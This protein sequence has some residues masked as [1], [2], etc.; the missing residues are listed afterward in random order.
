MSNQISAGG[1]R[2]GFLNMPKLPVSGFFARLGALAVDIILIVAGIHLVASTF[3]DFFFSI[4]LWAPYLTSG[5]MFFYFVALNGPYGRGQT[6]GKMILRIR[7]RDYAG[8]NITWRQAAL[9]TVVLFPTFVT[10]PI[11]YVLLP[12][13]QGVWTDFWSAVLTHHLF[14]GVA[15]A[16]LLV[17]PFNP[18]KQG[19]HDFVAE[20]LV[21]G[22]APDNAVSFS[23]LT[24]QVGPG[25]VPF[26][27]QPQYS[28]IVTILLVLVLQFVLVNPMNFTTN[29]SELI[30]NIYSLEEVPGFAES[31]P[32]YA[33]IEE[34][35]YEL[36]TNPDAAASKPPV[37]ADQQDTGTLRLVLQVSRPTTWS[38]DLDTSA[39]IT[40]AGN[41][42]NRYHAEVLPRFLDYVSAS[43]Q[44]AAKDRI[45]KWYGRPLEYRLVLAQRV[46]LIPYP[47]IY[48]E[49]GSTVIPTSPI[50]PPDYRNDT[51]EEQLK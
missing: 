21:S 30:K 1:N 39:G 8:Q 22:A 51:D 28:G 24:E 20:T 23:Q 38:I 34:S 14:L 41:Y 43:D 6:I 35:A 11:V 16:T 37:T 2:T 17:I 18:F 40:A 27:R 7:V 31:I 36:A 48:R 26:H 42:V 3:E 13:G 44:Q 47:P 12:S 10:V 32:S 45:S 5:F 33:P 49:H 15:V 4:P 46:S 19:M 50:V 29:Q 9:R 25:W